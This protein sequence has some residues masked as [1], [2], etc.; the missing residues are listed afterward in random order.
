VL[1]PLAAVQRVA[2]P[3]EG[4]VAEAYLDLH[5]KQT[6]IC[7]YLY[8]NDPNMSIE[9]F[10][11]FVVL[12]REVLSEGDQTDTWDCDCVPWLFQTCV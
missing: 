10:V 1:F 4:V 9:V 12:S 11:T 2:E 5:R 7:V 3:P 8:I 6:Y